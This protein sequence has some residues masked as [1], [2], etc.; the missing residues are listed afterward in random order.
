M[1]EKT[2]GA[3][4]FVAAPLACMKSSRSLAKQLADLAAD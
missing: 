4:T 1:R 2:K 3:V